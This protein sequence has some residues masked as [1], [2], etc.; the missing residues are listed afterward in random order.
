MILGQAMMFFGMALL[1]LV[2]I[3]F[4]ISFILSF[5]YFSRQTKKEDSEVNYWIIGTLSFFASLIAVLIVFIT[6]YL[7]LYFSS[8]E[9]LYTATH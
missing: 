3:V 9:T 2:P 8:S 5:L 4:L 1:V 7:L 6:L